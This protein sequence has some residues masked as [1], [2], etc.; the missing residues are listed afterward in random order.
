MCL[1]AVR[2]GTVLIPAGANVVITGFQA[3]SV[4]ITL[5]SLVNKLHGT[6]YILKN[7]IFTSRMNNLPPFLPDL[8]L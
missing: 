3:A 4:P 6:V 1:N 7:S 2:E 5:I 8:A